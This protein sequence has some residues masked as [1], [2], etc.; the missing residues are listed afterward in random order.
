[1]AES[2]YGGK[3]GF[4]FII[5]KTFSSIEEM[6]KSF[7]QGP[8]YLAVHYDEHVIINTEN[9]NSPDN[10][11]VYRRGYEYTNDLGGA[12]YVGTIVGP[13]GR[14]PMLELTTIED[15]NTKH[16][17]EGFDERKGEGSYKAID[18]N[19]VPGKNEDG[20]FNDEIQWAYC[21]IRNENDEDCT[22]YIGFKVPYLV[23]EFT[24]ASVD[25]YYNRDKETSD[26]QNLNLTERVDDATHPFYEKWHFKIPKGIKGDTLKN[27]RVMTADASIEAYDGQDDDIENNREVLVYDYYNYDSKAEGDKTSVYLGDYN[28]I[29]D[30]NLENDGTLKINYSHDNQ[31]SFNK[32]IKWVDGIALDTETGHF[33][34]VYNQDTDAKGDPTLYEVDLK[35][36]KAIRVD[37][38]G[39]IQITYSTREVETLPYKIKWIDHINMGA[40]GIIRVIYNDTTTDILDQNIQWIKSVSLLEDGQFIVKYNNTNIPDYKTQLKWVKDINVQADGTVS[41][42]YNYGD[43]LTHKKYLK[44]INSISIQ[45]EDASGTEGSGDQKVHVSYNTGDEAVL[46]KPLNYI[47]KTAIT[48]DYHYIVYYSDPQLRAKIVEDKLN[49]TYEGKN[50]W[51]DLGSIKDESGILVGM[52][53]SLQDHPTLGDISS[54][55]TYLNNTYPNGLD[56]VDL[57]GKII[58]IGDSEDTKLFYAFDYSYVNGNYGGWFYLGSFNTSISNYFMLGKTSDADIEIKKTKL[59][60]GGLWFIVEEE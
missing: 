52:N 48:S 7:K 31:V 24:A 53:I 35:W 46:G 6:A 38:Q 30:I 26:F 37:E 15:V 56:G 20:S 4:S 33:T 41:I 39:N 29:K 17:A 13:A 59:S 14:S 12:L 9:K 57:K 25:A 3:P 5:V 44:T 60:P 51:F 42:L 58:S 11:K 55:I 43:A 34:V 23:A 19:L 1:M 40:D 18:G 50:D 16:A 21:S 2:F 10:G 47:M 36:V 54:A 22:A 27:F 45:T 28:M 49:Y 8:N 32:A